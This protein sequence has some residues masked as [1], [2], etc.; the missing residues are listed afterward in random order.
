MTQKRTIMGACEYSIA[1]LEHVRK[2]LINLDNANAEI[3]WAVGGIIC[4]LTSNLLQACNDVF[5]AAAQSGEAN[6]REDIRE[7]QSRFNAFVDRMVD[8][9]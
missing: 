6:A 8:Y 9:E 7:I 2:D 5:I 1:T 3:V 4:T